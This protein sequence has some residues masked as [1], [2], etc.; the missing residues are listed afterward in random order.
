MTK[1][2]KHQGTQEDID[3]I[4]AEAMQYVDSLL[5]HG[6]DRIVAV[7]WVGLFN[8]ANSYL[9]LYNKLMEKGILPPPSERGNSTR[10]H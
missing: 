6:K 9:F 2:I 7:E 8:L 4:A 10:I 1:Q 3:S 5:K